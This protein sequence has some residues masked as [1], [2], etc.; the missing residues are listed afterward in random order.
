[1]TV[2]TAPA[3]APLP[4]A[5]RGSALGRL[6]VI[7]FKLFFR[8]RSKYIVR[9]LI[10]LVL[11]VIFGMVPFYT[12]DR[13]SLD[14]HSLL[15]AYVPIL[16]AYSLAMLSLTALPIV[17]AGYREKGVL[18]RLKTT[19]AGPARVL[20]AQLIA[21]VS[22][23]ALMAVLVVVVA[24]LGYGVAFPR[25]A[26]G[27]ILAGLLAA[28]AMMAVGLLIAAVA[29]SA[30]SAQTIGMGLL[31]PLMFFAGLFFPIPVMPSALRHLSHATPLGAAVQALQDAWLGHWPHP[32]QWLTMLIYLVIC[33]L[34][35]A[36]LF[37]WE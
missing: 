20:A 10:P 31:L 5:T 14:G 3:T 16:I 26:A 25:Q 33:V 28:A 29:P 27:F 17:L 22:I 19:P 12:Q 35:A 7:E 23:A 6:V 34:A 36:R 1:M 15:D 24:R 18:R 2:S 9:M 30:Q 11:L 8:E 13:A 4:R 21:Y 37:R 32:L